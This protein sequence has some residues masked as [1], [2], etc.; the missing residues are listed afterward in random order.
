[1]LIFV[2]SCQTCIAPVGFWDPL[3]LSKGIDENRFRQYRTAELKH[4][5]VAMAAVTGYVVQESARFPGYIAPGIDLK[6]SDVPNG[7]AALSTVPLLGWVQIVLFVGW[8]EYTVCKQDPDRAP[9]MY[10]HVCEYEYMYAHR[11][12][13]MLTPHIRYCRYVTY[14][15]TNHHNTLYDTKYYMVLN[16]CTRTYIHTYIYM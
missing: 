1:M 6:F 2:L 13:G 8:L 14:E 5:R 15:H 7:V 10:I 9:G 11:H 12:T 16:T 4:G 3:G